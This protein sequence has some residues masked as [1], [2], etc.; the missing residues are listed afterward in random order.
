[1]LQRVTDD[2]GLDAVTTQQP[3][4]LCDCQAPKVLQLRQQLQTFTC[5]RAPNHSKCQ[6]KQ[7]GKK[8]PVSSESVACLSRQSLQYHQL[9]VELQHVEFSNSC[10]CSA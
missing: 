8:C 5:N 9:R 2:S 1:M 3:E 6:K 4:T 7:E 10:C